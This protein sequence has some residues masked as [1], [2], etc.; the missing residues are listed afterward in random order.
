MKIRNTV[1]VHVLGAAAL[2]AWF[3]N[4]AAFAAS[5]PVTV[6]PG[7]AGVAIPSYLGSAPSYTLLGTPDIQSAMSGSTLFGFDEVAFKSS[8]LDPYGPNA[9][10]FAFAVASSSSGPLTLTMTGFTGYAT[11]LETCDPL[12]ITA[13]QNCAGTSAGTVSR[14]S[15]GSTLNFASMGLTATTISGHTMNL[16]NIYGIFTNA[17]SSTD[18]GVQVCDPSV[19][20]TTCYSFPLLGPA[21]ATTSSVPEPASFA[22]L[23]LGL[24]G[25]GFMRR[26][27]AI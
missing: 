20:A 9:V 22:L 10:S 16:T 8:M 2:G 5:A 15:D 3:A 25:I 14:S 18:P 13:N 12:A 6:N 24:I 7:D 19:S 17:T 1:R 27:R 23:G 21:G 4:P 26:K 11:Q